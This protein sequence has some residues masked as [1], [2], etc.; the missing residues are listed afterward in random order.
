MKTHSETNQGSLSDIT[1]E[2]YFSSETQNPLIDLRAPVE[3]TKGS[4][5]HAVNVAIFDDN[6]RHEIGCVYKAQGERS[7]QQLGLQ[8]FAMSCDRFLSDIEQLAP[9]RRLDLFCARGGQ[10]SRATATW[11]AAAGIHVRRVLGG[12]KSYRQWVLQQ[13]EDL[14]GHSL[15]VLDGRTGSGKT[16][17]LRHCQ[18]EGMPVVDFE[19][20][21][22][23]RG[24]AFG[25][26]GIPVQE[27]S[28]QR[29]E[30]QI[31]Q[32]YRKIRH[33]SRILVELENSIGNVRLPL[34]IR[35]QVYRSPMV[36]LESSLEKRVKLLL[37]EYDTK[38]DPAVLHQRL[39]LL[40]RHLSGERWS[41]LTDLVDQGQTG[42]LIHRLLT[43][44]YDPRYDKGLKKRNRFVATTV[45]WLAEPEQ[46]TKK[47][48]PLLV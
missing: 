12:Y 10:R 25:D 14:A 3:Y 1:W 19:G 37:E 36:L 34:D 29:F 44:H 42:E 28:Q 35:R 40:K 38:V 45:D 7:A 26:L 24:S 21:A 9:E 15:L 46:S 18:R 30:N 2:E 13:L 43:W 17:M 20:F 41:E 48:A 33:H 27:T 39:Q 4:A 6:E 8:F 16:A 32:C 22:G 5:P 11:L 23:H 47:L 31:A